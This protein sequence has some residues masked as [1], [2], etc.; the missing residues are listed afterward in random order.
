MQVCGVSEDYR[1]WGAG[2]W[3]WGKNGVEGGLR[4][5]EGYVWHACVC[6]G[7]RV[8]MYSMECGEHVRTDIWCVLVCTWREGGC[9]IVSGTVLCTVQFTIT[10]PLV[11]LS[12]RIGTSSSASTHTSAQ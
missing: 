4:R 1:G 5:V 8:G 10:W 12:A 3:G 9:Q 6:T 11:L 2:V 7:V